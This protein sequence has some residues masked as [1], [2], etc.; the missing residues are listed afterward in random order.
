MVV[1]GQ[2]AGGCHDALGGDALAGD[3]D[4]THGVTYHAGVGE[5]EEFGDGAIGGDAAARDL[6]DHFMDHI[7]GRYFAFTRGAYGDEAFLFRGLL[8]FR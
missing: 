7:D 2:E 4:E 5:V 8:Y 3:V 6:A 1:V